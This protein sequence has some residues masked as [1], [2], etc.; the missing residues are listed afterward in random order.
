MKKIWIIAVMALSLG[1]CSSAVDNGKSTDNNGNETQ[2]DSTQQGSGV[3]MESTG[4]P[5]HLSEADF[6]NNVFDFTKGGNWQYK[7]DKP[8]I[9]DFYADWCGPCRM[10]APYMEEMAATY[11]NDIYVYKVNTD[12]AQT[13][14]QYFG[15]NSIPA[16]MFVPMSGEPQMAV[17]ANEKSFYTDMV[18]KVLLVK[19]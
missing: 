19:K 13:L 16:V 15:I 1:A 12:Y 14:A 11:K 17:G 6:K 4:K 2:V 9:I 8:C 18:K 5:I 10:I 3:K 7:G